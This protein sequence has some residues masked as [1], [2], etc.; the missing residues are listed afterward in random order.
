[1][2]QT[3]PNQI[4]LI[5]DTK[6]GQVMVL[7]VLW[8][9][10]CLLQQHQ[11][12]A[13]SAQFSSVLPWVWLNFAR[14]VKALSCAL[15][16]SHRS[17]VYKGCQAFPSFR[18]SQKRAHGIWCFSPIPCLTWEATPC[19]GWPQSLI[20]A[21]VCAFRAE[22]RWA[23]NLARLG[24]VVSQPISFFLISVCKRPL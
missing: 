2:S 16:L 9:P 6:G 24:F 1:M 21:H 13:R 5:K 4:L 23:C 7:G 10:L 17:P 18:A 15:H 19:L 22:L 11:A 3:S 12:G 20:Y 14:G 8:E